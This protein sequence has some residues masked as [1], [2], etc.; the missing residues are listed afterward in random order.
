MEPDFDVLNEAAQRIW[1]LNVTN[2]Q[3][4]E[5]GNG[6]RHWAVNGVSFSCVCYCHVAARKQRQI[7]VLYYV[8]RTPFYLHAL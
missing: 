5:G 3:T 8:L 2:G 1:C 6:T 7:V 4:V